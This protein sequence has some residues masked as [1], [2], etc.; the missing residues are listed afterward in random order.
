MKGRR[1]SFELYKISCIWGFGEICT[2]ICYALIKDAIFLCSFII[3]GDIN[4]FQQNL[5]KRDQNS[6]N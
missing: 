3:R 4:L 1:T 5:T 2:R 6:F